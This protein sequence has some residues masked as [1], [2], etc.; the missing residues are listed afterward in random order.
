M[1]VIL[2][3]GLW[4]NLLFGNIMNFTPPG[5]WGSESQ[6]QETVVPL[7]FWRGCSDRTL[8]FVSSTVKTMSIKEM[9]KKN[10]KVKEMANTRPQHAFLFLLAYSSSRL[11]VW[12]FCMVECASPPELMIKQWA[13]KS[14]GVDLST[15]DA[16]K[17]KSRSMAWFWVINSETTAN[18]H[19]SLLIIISLIYLIFYLQKA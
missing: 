14:V 5:S 19:T 1:K 8:I 11:I 13:G 6:N 18:K 12:K 4:G 16:P 2:T 7:S 9:V 10:S 15:V 17:Y 3:V